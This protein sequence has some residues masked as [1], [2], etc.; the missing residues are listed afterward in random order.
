MNY[1]GEKNYMAH[2]TSS[3]R[4]IGPGPAAYDTRSRDTATPIKIKD[5]P[6]EKK[7]PVDPP[8]YDI[9]STIGTQTPIKI[10]TNPTPPK[11][12]DTPGPSYV[13]PAFGSDTRRVGGSVSSLWNAKDPK[14]ARKRVRGS[15]TALGR[16][17]DPYRTAGPGPAMYS[18]RI[19]DFDGH[20]SKGTKISGHHEFDYGNRDSPGPGAYLPQYDKVLPSAPKYGMRSRHKEKDPRRG[21]AYRNLGSTLGGP[22]FS[23]QKRVDDEVF[24]C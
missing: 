10:H 21:A 11:P 18:L 12:F 24:L 19:K 8:Y 5:R 6:P 20:A 17:R 22:K 9:G 1:P 13:P 4:R 2:I 23:I 3:G 7:R 16:K 14:S 15:A